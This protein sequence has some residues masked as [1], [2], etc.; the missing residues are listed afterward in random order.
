MTWPLAFSVAVAFDDDLVGVVRK[1]IDRTLSKDRIVKQRNPLVDGAVA[2][3]DGGRASVSFEDDFV[4][5]AGLLGI[6]T[7]QAEVVDDED[8]GGEQAT[9]DFLGGVIGARLMKSLQEMIG[10]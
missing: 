4:E 2:G 1:S 8:V 7:T 9:Q 3:E 5:I 6:E 10:T